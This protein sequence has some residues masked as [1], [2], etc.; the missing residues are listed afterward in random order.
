MPENRNSFNQIHS[1]NQDQMGSHDGTVQ[2]ERQDDTADMASLLRELPEPGEAMG[3]FTVVS[4]EP[5]PEYNSVG[6]LLEENTSKARL[7]HVYNR[8]EENL[9][10]FNF[11][12]L[13]EN[14]NGVAHILEHTVLC[15]S[16][17]YPVKDPFVMLYR[18]SMQTF[19]NA[20]TF[21]DKTIYPAASTVKEDLFNL[22][23]VY[24]DA[25]F[26]PLLKED[27]F[28]Q[29][30]HRLELDENGEPRIAGVVYNEMKANYST[31]DS[32]AGDMCYRSLFPDTPYRHDS[33]GDPE[34]IPQLSYEEFL[35]FHKRYYHPSN[36]LFFFYGN[37]PTSEYLDFVD[38]MV[39]SRFSR[40]ELEKITSVTVPVQK[41][42]KEPAQFSYSYPVSPES[43]EKSS[44]NL[45]WLLAEMN[46]PVE[47]LG[48]EVLSDLLMGSPASP[49]Q[50]IINE[51]DLGEDL[52]NSSGL[53]NDLRQLVFTCGM[54]GTHEDR[55]DEIETLILDGLDKLVREGF[56]PE[57]V[58][59][60]LSRFEFRAR[61]IKGGGPYGLKLLIRGLRGWLHGRAPGESMEFTPYLQE[62]KKRLEKNPSYFIDLVKRHLLEN[63]HR[64]RVTVYPDSDQN[65]REEEH[66]QELL[67]KKVESL[68]ENAM[69]QIAEETG[70][71]REFQ[72]EP[73]SPEAIASL[74]YLS[75]DDIPRKV[76]SI[77]NELDAVPGSNRSM[78]VHEVFTNG[79]SYIDLGFDIAGLEEEFQLFIPFIAHI[80]PQIGAGNRD[81]SEMNMQWGLQTGGFSMYS[82]H[83]QSVDG[84]YLEYAYL[85][86]KTLDEKSESGLKL[87]KDVL[88]AAD[89]K[90]Y[91]YLWDLFL[92]FRND[93]R[94]HIVPS[95]T[96]FPAIRAL[97]GVSRQS[98]RDDVWKGV[99]QGSFVELIHSK[100]EELGKDQA[101]KMLGEIL[102]YLIYRIF[103]SENLLANITCQ[104][105]QRAVL[106][107]QLEDFIR[108]LEA[109][110]PVA[111]VGENP[112]LSAV[113]HEITPGISRVQPGLEGI[114][115]S[116]KV[117][118]TAMALE[119]SR[120]TMETQIH[121]QLLA[122]ILR[123]GYL[124]EKIRMEGGAYGAFC[125]SDSLAGTMMFGSYRD[126]AIQS[127]WK[128]YEN[129]LRHLA[130]AALSEQ[131][132]DFA[133]I[134]VAGRE[135]RPMS[136]AEK[137]MISFKR[138]K[139]N[140]TDELRQ[141][142]REWLLRT[143]PADIQAAA[144]RLLENMKSGY[145]A[146]LGDQSSLQELKKDLPD[147]QVVKL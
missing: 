18:S 53:E 132:L 67:K 110:S 79:I 13:P 20:M 12:T 26:F 116:C 52:S 91:G 23:S 37:I 87:V 98:L 127:S 39:F 139:Y 24:A 32:I 73:D 9:F 76:R 123:S 85:R 106:A 142:R 109:A 90:D 108:E 30:G 75:V 27:H 92:E 147:L 101:G 57:L 82:E 100:G 71:F 38:S 118:F 7:Y 103:Q 112:I 83:S 138:Q 97:R 128:S 41:Q 88:T 136:P 47:A 72:H 56:D 65:E 19:L 44:V 105:E 50:R 33:G 16:Q 143:T 141:Q 66:E 111:P 96:N 42:W 77:P 29:E 140:I 11:A 135:L 69:D 93:F 62:L 104:N 129:G 124:W 144:A 28:R 55:A 145:R 107:G 59:A 86:L 49:I 117:N 14:S 64:S 125:V 54:R 131:E 36:C 48:M 40:S 81:Y 133:K 130:G 17:K 5:L 120:I 31:H 78:Y 119:A 70:K 45:N 68:G 122:H 95:G 58:K 89:M 63:P 21:P 22:M 74:P 35:G 115:H 80:L 1:H 43:D 4:R 6:V 113:I 3:R 102:Q 46:D 60:S 121:E 10:S 2:G 114:A 94:S 134:A 15:G 8:D 146:V 126:P 137:G 34:E 25:V 51:S 61:E 99:I 84:R